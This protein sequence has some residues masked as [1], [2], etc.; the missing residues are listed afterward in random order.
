MSYF[1]ENLL[2]WFKE[3]GR[4]DL[5]WQQNPT[6]Y[7]VWVSEIM[8][9]QTQVSTVIEYYQR[10]M[11]EFS[12]IKLVSDATQDHVLSYWSGLGYYARGRNLHRSAQI[13]VNDLFEIFPTT[14]EG[15]C[16]LPGI[17]RSTA[18]AILS[19]GMNIRAPI[20]D[21]NV[22]RVLARF[23]AIEGATNENSTLKQLWAL[24]EQHT[25]EKN[26]SEYTQAIMDLGATICTRSKPLCHQCPVAEHCQ[27][28]LM[29]KT[30]VLPQ[31]KKKPN[32]R[33][34]KIIRLL[35]LKTPDDHLLLEKRANIGI[36]GGLWSF[37]ECEMGVNFQQLCSQ[38]FGLLSGN[39]QELEAIFHQFTH[40][41]LEIRPLLLC[42]NIRNEN[43]IMEDSGRF[44][45][46]LST[47]LA[48][49][50]PAPVTQLLNK[51]KG[52]K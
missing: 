14:V 46:H 38:K 50:V 34:K 24:A 6:P 32:S 36:W 2:S 22:K 15:L 29:G 19:L 18:G 10:F 1:S 25:P 5:P 17:G 8:L 48:V 35:I 21:G 52:V 45:Y 37:P 30:H 13:I 42:V 44:W 41:E 9:Q 31:T 39:E 27:A 40:F 23:Y 49:G 4:H 26:F 12:S 11:K 3:Q 33:P 28:F 43:R 51:L 16:A 7:R 20:L 47:P